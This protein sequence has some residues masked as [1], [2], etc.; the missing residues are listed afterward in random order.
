MATNTP[1]SAE[2]R[3][4][5]RSGFLRNC[6]I[7]ATVL[8]VL[9]VVARHVFL[10]ARPISITPVTGSET[11]Y[12]IV[13][14]AADLLRLGGDLARTGVGVAP[15]ES[16]ALAAGPRLP[17]V[18]DKQQM[19]DDISLYADPLVETYSVGPD[20]A[21]GFQRVTAPPDQVED[22]LRAQMPSGGWELA[23]EQE[24]AWGRLLVW[25]KE[26]RAC[27]M[28]VVGAETAT[29]IWIRYSEGATHG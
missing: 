8:E 29:E 6:L 14:L 7:A 27:R 21:V 10:W 24:T 13:H 11:Q 5:K 18:D 25:E 9:A 26:D 28:E 17:G 3:S 2:S 20:Q 23:R 12:R 16:G 1:S 15:S 4:G 19:P 22:Y